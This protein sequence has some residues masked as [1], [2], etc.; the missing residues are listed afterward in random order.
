MATNKPNKCLT[1]D[2]AETEVFSVQRW[3]PPGSENEIWSNIMT[4]IGAMVGC[5]KTCVDYHFTP[6]AKNVAWK[7][8]DQIRLVMLW[9]DP[10]FMPMSQIAYIECQ[11]FMNESVRITH[12]QKDVVKGINEAGEM[13]QWA[14]ETFVLQTA[15]EWYSNMIGSVVGVYNEEFTLTVNGTQHFDDG[16]VKQMLIANLL[17]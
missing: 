12:I 10:D 14:K 13:F 9:S 6:I 8:G 11:E 2:G 7:L 1:D 17:L 15:P 5:R 16:Q 3:V 4:P